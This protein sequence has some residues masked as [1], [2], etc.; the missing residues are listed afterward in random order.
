[1]DTTTLLVHLNNGTL[2]EIE[3]INHYIK[4]NHHKP[5]RLKLPLR[6]H[7]MFN[8]NLRVPL[9]DIPT[10]TLY[11]LHDYVYTHSSKNTI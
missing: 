5:S 4:S 11:S 3:N 6:N 2:S 9:P 8:L 10:T 7:H 1:M